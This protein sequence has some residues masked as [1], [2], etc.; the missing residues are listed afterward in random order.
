MILLSRW[1]S[2]YPRGMSAT[3]RRSFLMSSG[4]AAAACA[5]PDGLLGQS[6]GA[7]AIA[8]DP[9]RPAYHLLPPHNWMNDPNGP[10]WW[11][12]KYHL[13]YQLNPQG[14]VWGQMHWGHAISTD[15]VHWHHEP[16][17]LAP[18]PGGP[19]SEGCF[20]GSAV[21]FEG[22][23]TILYT[24]VQNA[25]RNQSTI[26]DGD[27]H[28]RETQ[29]LAT[30]EGAD[31][32]RWKKSG[33]PVLAAPPVG[34]D[35]TGFRD[36]CPWHED[37]GWYLGVG[38]GERGKGGCVLLYRSKDLRHWEYLHKL[39]EGKWDGRQAANPVDSGEMWE[40]PD[41]FALPGKTGIHEGHVLLYSTQGK[42]VWTAGH[43]DRATHTFKADGEARPVDYGAYYAPKS[44]L[45]PDG[46]RILWG[47]IQE[48]RPQSAY[49]AAGWAGVMSLPRVLTLDASGRLAMTPAKEIEGLRGPRESARIGT[50]SPYRLKLPHLRRELHV[51][52]GAPHSTLTIRLAVQ[53]TTAWKLEF[54]GSSGVVRCG[55]IQFTAAQFANHPPELRMFLDGSVIETFVNAS[56]ALTSRVY[57]LHAETTEL[58]VEI[59]GAGT[60]IV[61]SW[62][63]RAIS[64]DRLTT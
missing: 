6:P 13:F 53:G 39:A 28:L 38:S 2:L 3:S 16:I 52:A 47:W 11:N 61:Q 30:A 56:G 41:F 32:L 25:P 15:M 60:G 20:S 10:I 4:C 29:L 46:R 49:S 18:T 9:L 62:P 64:Q 57:T 26:R 43:Y 34:L 24:G 58:M 59:D 42:S 5:F 40:C 48:T 35:V 55:D 54:N 27:N 45:A 51:Q 1:A 33:E 36:P 17:A 8:H 31:L 21:V 7:A 50:H 19:D 63:L 44:F 12:G 22:V 14:A 37:D 23:P